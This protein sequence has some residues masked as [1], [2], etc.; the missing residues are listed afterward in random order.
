M[1]LGS[2]ILIN[3]VWAD[4]AMAEYPGRGGKKINKKF[5]NV[6]SKEIA[7]TKRP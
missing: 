7:W 3:L 1:V 5:S 4:I 2:R 6:L